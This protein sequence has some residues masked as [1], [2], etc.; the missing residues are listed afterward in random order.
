MT[1]EPLMI[2]VTARAMSNGVDV[3]DDQLVWLEN[4]GRK[5]GPT[6]RWQVHII[7]ELYGEFFFEI[8]SVISVF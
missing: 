2:K 7:T 4:D 5:P 3:I 6:H 8:W 1:S